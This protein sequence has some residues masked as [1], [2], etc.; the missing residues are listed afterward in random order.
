M[1]IKAPLLLYYMLF[2]RSQKHFSPPALIV[3]HKE[4]IRNPSEYAFRPHTVGS[5]GFRAIGLGSSSEHRQ[6]RQNHPSCVGIQLPKLLCHLPPKLPRTVWESLYDSIL[7]YIM[8][9]ST[10][11]YCTPTVPYLTIWY[12]T[13]LYDVIR[14]HTILF[15]NMLSISAVCT[16]TELLSDC[17]EVAI[18]TKLLR[19]GNPRREFTHFERRTV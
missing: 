16:P 3:K 18:R 13:I 11:A 8:W 9:Y 15:Y 4:T 10:S 5:T 1:M 2:S 12:D 14:C 17:P 7:C 6:K 19:I